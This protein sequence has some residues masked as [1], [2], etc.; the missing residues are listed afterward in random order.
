MQT[1]QVRKKINN[2][3]LQMTNDGL[4]GNFKAMQ[5]LDSVKILDQHLL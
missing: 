2:N 3:V 1:K 4:I 5:E